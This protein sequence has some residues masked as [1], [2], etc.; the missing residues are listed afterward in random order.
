MSSSAPANQIVWRGTFIDCWQTPA[1]V[2]RRRAYSEDARA[3]RSAAAEL[4]TAEQEYL[5]ALPLRASSISS[6]EVSAGDPSPWPSVTDGD[7]VLDVVSASDPSPWPSVTDGDAVRDVEEHPL[8]SALLPAETRD[9]SASKRVEDSGGAA[10]SSCSPFAPSMHSVRPGLSSSQGQHAFAPDWGTEAAWSSNSGIVQSSAHP[11]LQVPLAA[12][13]EIGEVPELVEDN[14]QQLTMD[15]VGDLQMRVVELCSDIMKARAVPDEAVQRAVEHIAAIPEIVMSSM[16]GS[17]A[18]VKG[19]IQQHIGRFEEAACGRPVSR[20]QVVTGTARIRAEVEAAASHSL[21]LAVADVR[22]RARGQLDCALAALPGCPE[23][24][25]GVRRLELEAPASVLDAFVAQAA[26]AACRG[27]Q[28][29]AAGTQHAVA[30]GAAAGAWARGG[31]AGHARAPSG[32]EV[33]SVGSVGHPRLCTRPCIFFAEGE[34]VKGSSCTYCHLAHGS[35]PRHL[36]KFS[37]DT[38]KA[39]TFEQRVAVTLPVL[40][41]IAASQG[42][43]AQA[44]PLLSA[45]E[46]SARALRG[47]ARL[48]LAMPDSQRRRLT[49]SLLGLSFRTVLGHA[50]GGDDVP[51]SLKPAALHESIN[52]IARS[53]FQAQTRERGCLDGAR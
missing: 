38:L 20:M 12:L 29:V 1:D 45:V 48:R 33:L 6:E 41:Q 23:L 40:R 52:H 51:D 5:R 44:E 9:E 39:L 7:D 13:A 26:A 3:N 28:Q 34:C 50:C 8:E 30:P 37:R 53:V 25:E 47:P 19:I 24:A 46:A 42:F 14:L 16:K 31:A 10:S 32:G 21:R 36:D 18:E 43:G 2:P 17:A 27:L 4:F 22:S 11:Q 35:R 49:R 15:I